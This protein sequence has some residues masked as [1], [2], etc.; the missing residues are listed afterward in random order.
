MRAMG[1]VAIIL[2]S[3][4]L[5]IATIKGVC[6]LSD[7]DKKTDKKMFGIEL[8][9]Y[10]NDKICVIAVVIIFFILATIG[11]VYLFLTRC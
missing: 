11:V 2:I 9:D 6:C 1:T 7:F 4:V 3:I 8:E 5:C 10:E